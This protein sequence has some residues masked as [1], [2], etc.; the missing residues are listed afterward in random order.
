MVVNETHEKIIRV[1]NKNGPSLPIN[2]AKEL[3]IS[4]LFISA[5][6]SELS[7]EKRIKMSNLK[8]GGSPLYYLEGQEEKLENYYKFMHPK[9]SEAFLLLKENK[10]LKD[11]DQ[12]PAIRVALRSIRDFAAGFRI[13]E[14]IYWK[15]ILVSNEEID[16]LL[17]RNKKVTP[18]KADINI[19]KEEKIINK[20]PKENKKQEFEN[21]LV[22]KSDKPKKDKPK[23]EFVLNIINFIN[24]NGIEIIEERDY[25][26]K[27]Y[28]C[29]TKIKSTLGD[30]N[31][32]THA[33]NKKTISESD[34]SKLLST[35][36]SIP[37][38]AFFIY[39]GNISKKARE[40]LLR[41]KSIL[42]AKKFE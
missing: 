35:A 5:F 15:Y 29:I 16:N 41:Y 7:N 40:Y 21:P 32:L 8:V 10:M 4:S 12:D 1:L 14:D 28:N 27:E 36:Q 30:I 42:K 13:G 17:N 18:E 19:I 38:P 34:F 2:I 25:K 6:L 3:R 33:K 20:K 24:K 31:F 23:S 39:T 22:Q 11:S 9:E 26:S 37:L